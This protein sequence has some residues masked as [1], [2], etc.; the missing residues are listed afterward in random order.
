VV[1]AWFTWLDR[2]MIGAL[3]AV[4]ASRLIQALR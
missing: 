2:V 4:W 1:G 3:S